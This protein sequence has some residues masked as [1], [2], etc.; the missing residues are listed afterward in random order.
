MGGPLVTAGGIVF[1][2][3]T[4]EKT[5]RTFDIETGKTLWSAW[6]PSSANGTPTTY[7]ANG[8]QSFV[9]PAAGCGYGSPAGVSD[10]LVV[11]A[12]SE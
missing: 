9:F 2:G 5:V 8:R 1:I 12:Q 6:V 10:A 3:A 11:F 4:I 7:R